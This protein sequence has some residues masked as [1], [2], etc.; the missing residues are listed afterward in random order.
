MNMCRYKRTYETCCNVNEQ[1]KVLCPTISRDKIQVVVVED[2]A[3]YVSPCY[4]LRSC[5][6]RVCACGY[7]WWCCSVAVRVAVQNRQR[8]SYY[9][10]LLL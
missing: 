6:L 5:V 4:L 7:W 10:D 9:R 2:L 8:S 3:R 1:A